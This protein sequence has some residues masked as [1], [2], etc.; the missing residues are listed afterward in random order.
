M[1]VALLIPCYNSSA[2]LAG[3]L[4][5]AR[6]QLE[7]FDEIICY[8]DNSSDNS[9]EIADE[10][11]ARVIRGKRNRG[12]LFARTALLHASR[13]DYVHFHDDDDPL[14]PHFVATHKPFLDANRATICGFAKMPL[15]GSEERFGYAE[16]GLVADQVRFALKKFVHVNA[17]VF[18]RDSLI[19]SG[20]FNA[21][22]RVFEEKC[23][24]LQYTLCGGTLFTIAEDA[25]VWRLRADSA[26]HKTGGSMHN[27]CLHVMAADVFPLLCE[28]RPDLVMDFIH[29]VSECAWERYL[30]D[31]TTVYL[32]AIYQLFQ[33]HPPHAAFRLG[34]VAGPRAS[35]FIR[36]LW[37]RRSRRR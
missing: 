23:A 26:M 21:N 1:S 8:D 25:A 15:S 18:A 30:M 7:P 6:E 17:I 5:G 3:V 11:G 28:R 22:L 14:L 27:Y 10:L 20:A 34:K 12:A 37:S 4:G 29:Y 2:T 16:T 24:L 9:A 19:A 33:P 36:W 35:M 13:A 32:D 31:G